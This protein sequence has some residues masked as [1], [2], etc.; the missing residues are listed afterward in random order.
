MVSAAST[1]RG[2]NTPGSLKAASRPAVPTTTHF[3]STAAAS[4][5]GSLIA[6]LP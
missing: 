4:R 6:H 1:S 3:R 5:A 2:S